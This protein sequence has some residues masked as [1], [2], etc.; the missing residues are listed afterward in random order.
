[1]FFSPRVLV[2]GALGCTRSIRGNPRKSAVPLTQ[3]NV[4]ARRSFGRCAP[5]GLEQPLH[6]AEEPARL[7]VRQLAGE[8]AVE[9]LGKGADVGVAIG[10]AL[11]EAAHDDVLD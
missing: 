4:G 9:L 10:G 7:V 11:R 6:L 1:M 3:A 8:R 2:R 5:S